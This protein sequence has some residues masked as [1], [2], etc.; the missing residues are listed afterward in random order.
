MRFTSMVPY[1][2]N[3]PSPSR[4][5]RSVVRGKGSKHSPWPISR[6]TKVGQA[7]GSL[8]TATYSFSDGSLSVLSSPPSLLTLVRS[9]FCSFSMLMACWVPAEAG[10]AA[11]AVGASLLS[12]EVGFPGCKRV[13]G[14]DETTAFWWPSSTCL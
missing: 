14:K 1:P 5:G 13:K 2:A 6:M 3:S 10:D 7:E 9:R 11:G 8:S 4:E 12:A